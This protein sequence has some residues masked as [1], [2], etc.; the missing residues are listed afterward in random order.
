MALR[1]ERPWDSNVA[2]TC[3]ARPASAANTSAASGVIHTAPLTMSSSRNPACQTA[4]RTGMPKTN[5][6]P[7]HS[8]VA[9]ARSVC[10][11]VDNLAI[12]PWLMPPFENVV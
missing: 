8:Q 6:I 7:P 12:S 2:W 9:R 1:R 5:S 3:S 10:P 4:I 11:G